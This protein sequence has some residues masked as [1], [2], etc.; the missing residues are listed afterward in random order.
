VKLK[1][2]SLSFSGLLFQAY[3]YFEAR[4]TGA[5]L[6]QP[7]HMDNPARTRRFHDFSLAEVLRIGQSRSGRGMAQ[8]AEKSSTRFG[9]GRIQPTEI[10]DESIPMTTLVEPTAPAYKDRFDGLMIFGILTLLLGGLAGLLVLLMLVQRRRPE[11]CVRRR[12]A[13][14]P[15]CCGIHLRRAGSCADLAGIGSIQARRWARALLLIFSWS[16]LVMGIL[17]LIVMTFVM[18]KVLANVNDVEISSA[19]QN[20]TLPPAAIGIVMVVMLLSSESFSSCCRR[21]G[22]FFYN[23]RHVK[24]PAKCAIQ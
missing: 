17:V 2:F 3:L 9:N 4:V 8:A 20:H 14:R 11:P 23:S 7:Q 21:S 22:R 13:S 19:N 24:A 18:P 16:W 15:S 6:S 10:Y 5:R 12:S 1:R